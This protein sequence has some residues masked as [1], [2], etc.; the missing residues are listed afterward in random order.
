MTVVIADGVCRAHDPA[1]L[2][3][4]AVAQRHE[5]TVHRPADSFQMV[6]TA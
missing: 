2:F 6:N 4:L 1:Q 5:L 3:P